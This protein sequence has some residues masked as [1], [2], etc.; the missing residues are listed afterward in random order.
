MK[1]AALVMLVVLLAACQPAPPTT[2][3][4]V[5][6]LPTD[7]PPVAVE[8]TAPPAHTP[9]A[10]QPPAEPQPPGADKPRYQINA[11]L[12][13]SLRGLQ[14]VEE[15]R[16]TNPSGSAL[17]SLPLAVEANRYPGAFEWLGAAGSEEFREISRTYLR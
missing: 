17:E 5:P 16:F 6:A 13:D 12:D 7:A 3:P 8:T 9:A 14:V 4:P 2:V 10:P 15:I 11:V 1:K